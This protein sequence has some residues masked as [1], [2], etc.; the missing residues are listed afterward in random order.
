[1]IRFGSSITNYEYNATI[2]NRE[3]TSPKIGH[4]LCHIITGNYV[5]LLNHKKENYKI[6]HP[7]QIIST[8]H[9]LQFFN[10]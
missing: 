7:K 3:L 4:K 10:V 9:D 5:D 1:M 8:V 2:F 6:D